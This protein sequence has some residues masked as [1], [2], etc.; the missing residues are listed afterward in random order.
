MQDAR[1]GDG[2]EQR[3]SRVLSEIPGQIAVAVSGGV[4]SLTLAAFAHRRAG[5]RVAMFHAVSPAVPGDATARVERLAA[6]QGWRLRIVDAGEFGDAA[7]RANPVNRCFFCKTN[8]YGAIA[9]H[10]DAQIVSG[11][12]LD[13]LGEYRP[14]LDAARD[15]RVRHPYLDAEIDKRGVRALAQAIGLGAV[16]ELPA[17]PCLSSRVETGIAIRPDV[18]RAIHAVER[19]LA[20]DFPH[21]IVRCRVRAKGIVIELDPATLAAIKGAREDAARRHADQAFAG[22]LPATDLTFALYRNGSA[23]LHVSA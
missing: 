5:S 3:L 2:D 7:Y 1:S 12:N 4:D 15:H 21:A 13:D 22:L 18:L 19:D 20:K 9:R 14:G 16:S 11:A 10:T 17:A 23:F 6:A 8:L